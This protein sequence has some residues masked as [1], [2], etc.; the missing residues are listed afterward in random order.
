V[1][2][3][4]VARVAR[5]GLLLRARDAQIT[6]LVAA[7][8]ELVVGASAYGGRIE[9]VVP[10]TPA[11]FAAVATREQP[12]DRLRVR[13]EGDDTEVFVMRAESSLP[14]E[15]AW[16]DLVE[17]FCSVAGGKITARGASA[18]RQRIE[19]RYPARDR[20]TDAILIAAIDQLAEDIGVTAA[21]RQLWTRIHP[22]LGHGAEIALA[23]GFGS[24]QV[25]QHL[26][27]TYPISGWD[28]A[29]RLAGGLVL[30]N[31]DSQE[32][33]RR[34]GEVAGI[35]GSDQLTGIELVLGPHEPPDIV[36]WAKV[37]SR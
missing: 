37:A 1:N 28:V 10:A 8:P 25:S 19:I 21:Q 3:D 26:A 20:D 34:L 23:T 33:S 2:V 24:G 17:Q 27:I 32:A 12:A 7:T 15:P 18:R 36:V 6:P 16:L 4:D 14:T 31:A 9:L 30:S 35:L 5:V 11:A 22:Q 29:V 13:I